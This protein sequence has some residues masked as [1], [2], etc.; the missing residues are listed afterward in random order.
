MKEPEKPLPRIW[1]K[2]A[3]ALSTCSF[4][5]A[6]TLGVWLK[7]SLP[8]HHLPPPT[9]PAVRM[10]LSAHSTREGGNLLLS[11]NSDKYKI[12]CNWPSRV[13]TLMSSILSCHCSLILL[14]F[15]LSYCYYYYGSQSEL[16]LP[17]IL[18]IA[19]IAK[20]PSIQITRDWSFQSLSSCISQKRLNVIHPF[21]IRIRRS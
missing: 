17:S 10:K 16:Q 1:S 20:G 5:A 18:G 13:D 11:L 8:C 7:I 21:K 6:M 3:W 14:C 15:S 9:T 2:L 19:E 12:H 4:D